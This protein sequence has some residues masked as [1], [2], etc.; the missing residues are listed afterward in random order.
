MKTKTA[1]SRA[2]KPTTPGEL[3]AK[4][5]NDSPDEGGSIFLDDF[6]GKLPGSLRV[7]CVHA[8]K[9]TKGILFVVGRKGHQS[10]AVYGHMMEDYKN[11]PSFSHQNH[12]HNNRPSVASVISELESGSFRLRA[13]V[14]GQEIFIPVDTLELVPA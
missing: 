10:R 3:I 8:L 4:L 5:I 1:V 9:N 6:C 13:T 7:D 14:N 11:A 2:V 12:R